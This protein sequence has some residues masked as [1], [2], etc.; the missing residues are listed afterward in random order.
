M[1]HFGMPFATQR[2]PVDHGPSANA[3]ADGEVKNDLLAL[4]RAP[5]R[6]CQR[7]AIDIGIDD[8]RAG[9]TTLQRPGQIG[10]RPAGLC[11]LQYMAPLR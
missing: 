1:A 2:P 10:A 3:G 4:A 11:S 9:E 6:L 7:R 5:C 8:H